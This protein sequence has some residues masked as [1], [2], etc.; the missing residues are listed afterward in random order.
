MKSP[1]SAALP[2]HAQPEAEGVDGR[3]EQAD[4]HLAEQIAERLRAEEALRHYASRLEHLQRMSLA[5][6][7]ADSLTTVVQIAVSYV[8]ESINC[9]SA[10]I[11]LYD[12]QRAEL[13][14]I[15]S[16]GNQLPARARLPITMPDAL[17]AM[18]RGDIYVFT[19][20]QALA[21]DSPGLR[22]IAEMGGRAVLAVPV[23]AGETLLG[24]L[25]IAA[26]ELRSF[27]VEEVVIAREVCDLVAVAIHNRRLLEAEQKSRERERSLR[28]V[29]ASL[30]LGL[31]LDE[32]LR[33]ILDQLERLVPFSSA[34]IVLLDGW[35]L[36]FTARREVNVSQQQLD[37]VRDHTPPNLQRVF[38]TCQ[39]NLIDDAAT[40]DNWS[41]L[42]GF[43]YIRSWLGVP[44]MSK[45][46]CI[47]ALT[48]DR[49]QPRSITAEDV[50]LTL[51]FA[52]QAAVAIDNARLFNEV[53]SHAERL[54]AR[55]R[56]RTRELEALYGIT[57]AAIENPDLDRV[58]ARA[59]ELAIQA[60]GCSGGAIYLVQSGQPGLRLAAHAGRSEI[61][62]S[63]EAPANDFL[64]RLAPD[65]AP[66][67][68]D[69]RATA[70]PLPQGLFAAGVRAAAVAPL[71]SHGSGL[72]VLALWSDAADPFDGA[73]LLLTAIA[74][75]IGAAVDNIQLRQMTRQAA[76]IEERE[77][78]ARDLHDAV[79]QT[80]YS[81]GLF[82]EAARESARAGDLAQVE[83]YSQ[84]VVQ[85]V[86]QALGEMRLLLFELRTETLAQLGLAGAL[87]ERLHSVEERANIATR[88]RVEDV[89]A[90]PLVL[91]EAFYRVA[92]EALNN[93]LRHAHAQRV[94]VTLR[95]ADDRLTLVV[96]DDGVGF[97]RR[98]A[99]QHGGMGLESMEK[100][101][102]KV[103]GSIRIASR[104]GHG[105]RVEARAPLARAAHEGA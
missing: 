36:V 43:E 33:R 84:A 44:L 61:G 49:D 4:P 98:D 27:T 100:R 21:A 17:A 12:P 69:G 55:V 86:Y 102:H 92:L 88:L 9:R 6:L 62:L 14:V 85:R 52:N 19:D 81:A 38:V 74:D 50:E 40:A 11:S 42:P 30:T 66:W 41:A 91:E 103:G 71:R 34:S 39:P 90:L 64:S 93:A 57:A 5:L 82:A 77:R 10:G 105:T 78:L 18:N 2:G 1:S 8:E 31:G 67:I 47:G 53:Q 46:V 26:A 23:R 54:D 3:P 25:W 97:R 99:A 56:E 63:A 89:G 94:S 37:A 87:R 51:A 35:R 73:S 68:A 79:T 24:L 45:G 29:G 13:S 48:I 32:V 20:A 70:G 58:L 59:L 16:S 65:G 95:A 28:E 60:F 83:R 101:I 72:G 96:H 15:R 75:Q 7:S 76:I 104:P 22:W 80:V